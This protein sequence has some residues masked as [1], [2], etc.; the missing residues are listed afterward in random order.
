MQFACV[1]I[2]QKNIYSKESN[3]ELIFHDHNYAIEINFAPDDG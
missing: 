1:E 3:L 2:S